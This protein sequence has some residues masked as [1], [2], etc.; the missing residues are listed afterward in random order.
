MFIIVIVIS[1]DPEFHLI[2][3]TRIFKKNTIVSLV[4]QVI[5]KI[6]T[7]LPPT[8]VKCLNEKVDF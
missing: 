7:P 2:R 5:N 6:N 1:C 8:N 3:L 4:L